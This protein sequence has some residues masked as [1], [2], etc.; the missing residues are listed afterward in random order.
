MIFT[1]DIDLW[2]SQADVAKREVLCRQDAERPSRPSSKPRIR[3]G[4][5]L[6]GARQKLRY[7]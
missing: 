1:Q 2:D 7:Q 6:F 4:I 5:I 3:D